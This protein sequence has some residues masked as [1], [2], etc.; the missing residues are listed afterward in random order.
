MQR[1]VHVSIRH[2]QRMLRHELAVV[3]GASKSGLPNT[4]K[5]PVGTEPLSTHCH[6]QAGWQIQCAA[7]F[8]GYEDCLA[9][10][11]GMRTAPE[12]AGRDPDQR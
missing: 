12:A 4:R 7:M 6:R 5:K 11:R 9:G 1:A 8:G 2:M 3:T 10:E